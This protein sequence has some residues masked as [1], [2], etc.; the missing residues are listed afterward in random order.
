MPT[1]ALKQLLK[2]TKK[3]SKQHFLVYLLKFF[4]LNPMFDII[5]F[6]RNILYEGVIPETNNVLR[7]F[8]ICLFILIIGYIIFKHLEKR[9]AEEL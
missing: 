6:Y 9:F 2:S 3:A 8:A 7:I 1:L 5:T 4:K